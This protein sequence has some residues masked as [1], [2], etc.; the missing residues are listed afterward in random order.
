M[1]RDGMIKPNVKVVI[2]GALLVVGVGALLRSWVRESPLTPQISEKSTLEASSRVSE[3]DPALV[4]QSQNRTQETSIPA[5]QPAKPYLH[6]QHVRVADEGDFSKRFAEACQQKDWA[7]VD[8]LLMAFAFRLNQNP[9]DLTP[10]HLR[11]TLE[12]LDR[13][14][15]KEAELIQF[16]PEFAEYRVIYRAMLGDLEEA[17]R[18][19]TDLSQYHSDFLKKSKVCY[20]FYLKQKDPSVSW[21]RQEQQVRKCFRDGQGSSEL[22]LDLLG[23]ILLRGENKRARRVY[24]SYLKAFP[25]DGLIPLELMFRDIPMD[26]RTP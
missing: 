8:R 16:T 24:A 12:I 17:N 9:K 5:T 21:E 15:E 26:D 13:Y 14:A 22:V 20:E 25:H 1:M 11:R 2:L 18:A 23:P 6:S 3:P 10:P 4:G 7:L 19:F